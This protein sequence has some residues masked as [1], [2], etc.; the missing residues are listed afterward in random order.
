MGLH[1][2]IHRY[3]INQKHWVCIKVRIFLHQFSRRGLISR[4]LLGPITPFSN[5]WNLFNTVWFCMCIKPYAYEIMHVRFCPYQFGNMYFCTGRFWCV[6]CLSRVFVHVTFAHTRTKSNAFEKICVCK[7]ACMI[8]LYDTR[9]ENY[10]E[11]K[12]TRRNDYTY[13]ILASDWCINIHVYIL[14]RNGLYILRFIRFALYNSNEFCPLR[15]TM[16]PL[17]AWASCQIRKIAGCACVGNEGN[18]FSAT[19]G[20]RSR[21]ASRHVRNARAVTHA[22]IAN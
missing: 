12:N 11:E 22:R 15:P 14:S 3:Q 18:V 6:L 17:M 5:F 4:K 10:M 21:N 2:P 19:A 20:Q 16:C 9:M 1:W 8:L 7:I 13:W